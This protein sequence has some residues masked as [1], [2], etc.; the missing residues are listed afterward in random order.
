MAADPNQDLRHR[1]DE[2]LEQLLDLPETE[3]AGF[4]AG[5]ADLD[6]Q[7]RAEIE[8]VLAAAH[9]MSDEFLGGH[10]PESPTRLAPGTTLGRYVLEGAVGFGGMSAVYAAHDPAVDRSVAVK[11][12]VPLADDQAWRERFFRELRILGRITHDHVVRVYDFGEDRGLL[13][14]VTERLEGEDLGKAIAGGRTGDVQRKIDVARQIATALRDV[15]AVGI[16]HRD[17]K[18]ANIFVT[19][20][21]RVKLIDFGISR[22]NDGRGVTDAG[23]VAGTPEYMA[24]ERL[25][26]G[27][28]SPLIDIYSYG[29]L[30]YEL[31]TG[32]RLKP[33]S[34]S[35]HQVEA[36]PAFAASFPPD[37]PSDIFNLI[38]RAS[39]RDPLT[40]PQS[41]DEI[42]QRLSSVQDQPS[43]RDQ[44]IGPA[45]AASWTRMRIAAATAVLTVALL[46]VV[47]WWYQRRVESLQVEP[48]PNLSFEQATSMPAEET[49]P[50][51]SPD[52]R[53]LLF[54]SLAP[55]NS[56]IFLQAVGGGTPINLT[57]DS[58][59]DEYEGA[60]SPDGEMIAFRSDRDGGGLFLMGRTGES[61]K[62]L[63]RAGYHPAWSPDGKRIATSTEYAYDPTERARAGQLLVV[64]AASGQQNV[65][66]NSD[67]VQPHWSPHGQRIAYWAVEQSNRWRD[68]W[69]VSVADG[70]RTRITNDEA[71]DWNP[72][73]SPSGRYL[74]FLSNRSGAM[75]AW[76]IAVDEDTGNV[77]GSPELLTLPASTV[78]QLSISASGYLAYSTA[79]QEF[80]VWRSA[81]DQTKE[82]LQ[83]SATPLIDSTRNW[84]APAVSQDGQWVALISAPP[85]KEDI[86]IV[87][88]DGTGLT[89]LTND[90]SFDRGPAWSPDGRRLAFYSNRERNQQIWLINADGS[91][92]RRVTDEP[93]QGLVGPLWSPDGTQ[94]LATRQDANELV[95]F[96]PD[97]PWSTQKPR[98][99]AGISG[100]TS[101]AAFNWEK[102][103]QKIWAIGTS[104]ARALRAFDLQSATWGE[105]YAGIRW[106]SPLASAHKA[107]ASPG[108]GQILL[109]MRESGERKVLFSS[110]TNSTPEGVVSA[111]GRTLYFTQRR[112]AGDIFVGRPAG[113]PSAGR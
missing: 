39:A 97:Q 98:R 11:V 28:A 24:P 83:G 106:F 15:H 40:R 21:G 96:N 4:L 53:W 63:T 14:L 23:M 112:L 103:S 78:I 108:N 60:F 82:S 32:G 90:L 91:G 64:D 66:V 49:F 19:L 5:Q 31:F 7:T 38:F 33:S 95:V 110:P 3:R 68:I 109:L 79:L 99:I 59:S 74:Y 107:V 104:S 8:H 77:R 41:F 43:A 94:I 1:R 85:T 69:T 37:V 56:D 54:D 75:N 52:G 87:R 93:G 22:S 27:T 44:A 81:F 46:A 58:L 12:L 61:A 88:A 51:L 84:R 55:G 29:V 70:T 100:A 17:L 89:Q 6:A 67:A 35:G 45:V 25:S 2:I 36:H 13:Y 92:L 50:N 62:R 30:L 18:P 102:E 16:V 10:V 111:D 9:G 65:L 73:W 42:L 48:L 57:K 76:R 101:T 20:S 47:G 26:A 34:N 86:W 113:Q 71:L 80:S 105:S 72:V